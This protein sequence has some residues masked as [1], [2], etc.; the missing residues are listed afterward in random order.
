MSLI[1]LTAENFTSEV[2]EK[3]GVVLV[4]FYADWCGPCKMIAPIVEEISKERTDVT[5]GK[6][7]VDDCTELAVKY[8][9]ASIPTLL[10]IRDGVEV[11]R[12]VG[13]RP[14]EAILEALD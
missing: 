14:K 6:I 5:V 9:V 3:K 2:L 4:D 8:R 1:K 10:V 7:N 12:I 13:Y 11:E